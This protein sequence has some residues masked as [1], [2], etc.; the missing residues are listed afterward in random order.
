MNRCLWCSRTDGH[1][2]WC[3]ESGIE[4]DADNLDDG[5]NVSSD[6][7]K[8]VDDNF[9]GLLW[10]DGDTGTQEL[11]EA[12]FAILSKGQEI[13]NA[14]DLTDGQVAEIVYGKQA[15][16]I[17]ALINTR[18]EAVLDRVESE[19]IGKDEQ[20]GKKLWKPARNEFRSQQRYKLSALRKEV[21]DVL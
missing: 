19:I 3:A 18:I 6:V 9:Q 21:S 5:N 12:I 16:Q 13:H 15:N 20:Y 17:E 10:K 7:R 4:I 8:L 11:R 14:T 2:D 1:T